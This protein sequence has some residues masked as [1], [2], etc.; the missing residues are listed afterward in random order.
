[1]FAEVPAVV[2]DLAVWS[3]ALVSMIGA[4]SAVAAIVIRWMRRV[5]AEEVPAA[6]ERAIPQITQEQ[7]R[8]AAEHAVEPAAAA[9]HIEMRRM[10]AEFRPNGGSSLYD[11]VTSRIDGI[12]EILDAQDKTLDMLARGQRKLFAQLGPDDDSAET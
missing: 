3:A 5:V 8:E 1:M 10:L 4:F 12:E 2:R 6:V 9:L 11:R 7:M